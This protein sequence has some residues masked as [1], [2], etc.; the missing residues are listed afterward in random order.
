MD[1]SQKNSTNPW[2]GNIE[3]NMGQK[4]EKGTGYE[5]CFFLFLK[6]GLNFVIK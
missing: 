3:G 5:I 2:V 1:P 4:T 6:Y